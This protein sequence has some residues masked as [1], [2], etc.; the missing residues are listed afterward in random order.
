MTTPSNATPAA[1]AQRDAALGAFNNYKIAK[2]GEDPDDAEFL[3]TLATKYCVCVFFCL[4]TKLFFEEIYIL[5]Q[6][7]LI[8]TK[9]P[10][11][12]THQ[13]MHNVLFLVRNEYNALTKATPGMAVPSGYQAVTD[14]CR[15][16]QV[17]RNA[18]STVPAPITAND[19]SLA[20]I[21]EV[22]AEAKAKARL[23]HT[24]LF[25]SFY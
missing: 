17:A 19:R 13:P 21:A 16:I 23:F 12:L 14:F 1:V 3:L 22:I 2:A 20:E 7:K 10:I 9:D 15:E 25:F 5:R 8:A 18:A 6:E 24:R 4:L 11:L